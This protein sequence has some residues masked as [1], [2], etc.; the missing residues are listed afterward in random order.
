MRHT[1]LALIAALAPILAAAQAAPNTATITFNPPTAR[2]NGEP[3][4]GA[5]SYR[6]HQGLRGQPKTI[7]ATITVASAVV[8]V[9]LL[10]GREYCWQ[11]D[12]IETVDLTAG[13]PSELSNEACKRFPLAPPAPVSITVN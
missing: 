6:L 1:I 11:V 5:L 2:I 12:A 7:V 4:E 8:N 9:G 10:S 13:P 3:I